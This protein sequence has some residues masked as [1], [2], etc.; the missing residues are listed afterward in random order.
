MIF[1]C[2]T[3][4]YSSAHSKCGHGYFGGYSKDGHGCGYSVGVHSVIYKI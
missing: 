2:L 4:G 1:V 3:C